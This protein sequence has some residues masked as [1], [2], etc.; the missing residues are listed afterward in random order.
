MIFVL[1]NY[2]SFTYNLV[3]YIGMLETEV[4][5]VRNDQ[6]TPLEVV[7]MRPK[8][9]IISP[10]PKTPNE[11]GISKDLVKAARDR[12]PILGICL[13]HQAIGEVFS[14]RTIIA[15]EIVHGKS[16][17]VKHDQKGIFKGIKSPFEAG[18]YHSLVLEPKSISDSLEVIA[19]TEPD[20]IMGIKATQYPNIWGLQFHPESILTKENGFR[21]IKN[22]YEICCNASN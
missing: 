6:I 20:T 4:K 15:R 2:D 21:I 1:D 3:Q 17:Q 19:T 12:I 11:A 22:F 5:V 16:C 14:A 18:R 9:I 7:E 13:G 10:G 8:G